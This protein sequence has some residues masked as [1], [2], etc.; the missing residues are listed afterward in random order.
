M[1]GKVDTTRCAAHSDNPACYEEDHLISPED[2][3]DTT[4]PRNL[5]PAP[6]NTKV[7][8]TIIGAHRKDVLLRHSQVQ[9]NLIHTGDDLNHP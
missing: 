2:G 1:N 4:D 7:G 5:W 9:E 3:G 6:Y 8:G